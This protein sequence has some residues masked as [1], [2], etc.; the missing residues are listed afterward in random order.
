MKTMKVKTIP[1]ETFDM[2]CDICQ[3]ITSNTFDGK[4]SFFTSN[5]ESR[6]RIC[7]DCTM[8]LVCLCCARNIYDIA[9]NNN[10]QIRGACYHTESEMEPFFKTIF[11]NNRSAMIVKKNVAV[12]SQCYFD[13]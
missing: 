3:G 12:C 2:Y 10:F 4:F 8:T 7:S 13:I 1:E 11:Q 9:S 6:L 5:G